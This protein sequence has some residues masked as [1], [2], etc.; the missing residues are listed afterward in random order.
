[1]KFNIS[2]VVLCI[3]RV[4]AETNNFICIDGETINFENICN[5]VADCSDESDESR[6][7]CYHTL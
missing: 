4:W 3:Q 7:V 1:M 6:S 2:L 5:G